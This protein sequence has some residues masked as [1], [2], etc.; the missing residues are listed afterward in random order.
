MTINWINYTNHNATRNLPI[1]DSLSSA[2]SFLPEM[3]VTM[4]VFSGGQP[5]KGEGPRV[6]STRHDHGG[7]ADVFF[8]KNGR[9]L[10]WS[11]PDDQPIFQE[12]VRRAKANGVTGFGAGQGY[13]QPGSMHIGFGEPAVWGAGGSGA[14]APEWLR[15]AYD[16]GV[17]VA[18]ASGGVPAPPP[19]FTRNAAPPP[20]FNRRNA[21]PPGFTRRNPPAAGV[22]EGMGFVNR[23]IASGADALAGIVIDP[24]NSTAEYFTGSRPITDTPFADLMDATGVARSQRPP[25]TLGERALAGGGE[26]VSALLPFAKG[27]QALSAAPGMVGQVAR[28]LNAPLVS[29]PGRA[30]ATE[31][32]A[33]VGAGAGG[34]AAVR[35][36][37]SDNPA[38]RAGGEVAGGL[39]AALTPYAVVRA[40]GAILRRMPVTG[41]IIRRT[42]EAVAPFTKTGG[43][44]KAARRLQEL[45][46][47]PEA[48]AAAIESPS[49]SN[50]SPAQRT[51]DER[52]IALENTI[53]ANDPVV[54]DALKKQTSQAIGQLRGALRHEGDPNATRQFFSE[55]IGRLSEVLDARIEIAREKAGQFLAKLDPQR[56]ETVNSAIVRRELDKALLSAR[57]MENSLWRSVPMD[58]KVGTRNL[59]RTFDDIVSTTGAAQQEDI[60]TQARK[61]L[62]DAWV[63]NSDDLPFGFESGV[64]R[65]RE[66]TSREMVSLY[67]KLREIARGARS[68]QAPQRNKARIADSLADAILADLGAFADDPS[69]VGRAF[70]A[71]RQFSRE[72][73]QRFEQG[74]V[75]RI[76]GR[77]KDGGDA[78]NPELTLSGTVGRGGAQAKVA[79]DDF[80][81][82]T[83]GDQSNAAVS[84]FL[85]RQFNDAAVRNGA[86]DPARAEGFIRANREVLEQFPVVSRA[87]Q[88]AMGGQGAVDARIARSNIMRDNA[89]RSPEANFVNSPMEREFDALL[90]DKNPG[91]AAARILRTAAKDKNGLSLDGVKGALSDYLIRKASRVAKDGA[92]TLSGRRLKEVLNDSRAG[93]AIKRIMGKPGMSRLNRIA[94]EL[95]KAERAGEGGT[96]D[97][98]ILPDKPAA[99][100]SVIGRIIGAR[101]GAALGGGSGGSLQAA[102]IAS[103][104]VQKILQGLTVSRAER[105][106]IDAVQDPELFAA[107]LRD[108]SRPQLAKQIETKLSEWLAATGGQEISEE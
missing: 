81:A 61:V 26:A 54:D 97:G 105:L 79:V 4:E 47:N 21:P 94:D 17:R 30:A 45:S 60:A 52:L 51:G 82:A 69:A 38:I 73:S 62:E 89:S 78:V 22:T 72:I 15:E 68:G 91:Q 44:I 53:R 8:H 101:H 102:N 85:M 28:T 39:T 66:Q 100:I 59:Y 67:S 24:I 90:T 96:L 23:G 13:M 5:G 83:G 3:G 103:N 88:D 12:I 63:K 31:F 55:R 71:A 32:L 37:E 33:G 70:N 58:V 86:V 98:G 43:R 84:D 41:A 106:L 48:A 74:T 64:D 1:S 6:G 95:V 20:G 9:R 76:L 92:E 108:G 14:N 50:L 49:I 27:A 42:T 36:A 40:P 107:L 19:G 93:G 16:G 87:I 104:R 46:A 35:A 34:E 10:D 77:M 25:E 2:L 75:G 80:N 65:P 99:I 7:A 56:A 18:D 11:N 57:E 29:G